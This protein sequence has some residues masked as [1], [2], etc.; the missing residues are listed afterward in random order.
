M[1]L[2]YLCDRWLVG[3]VETVTRKLDELQQALGGFGRLL[4]LGMDYTEDRDAWFESMR[5]LSE[6]VV[7]NVTASAVPA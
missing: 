2:D 1:D 7:P 6:E 3:S 4:V 5:L